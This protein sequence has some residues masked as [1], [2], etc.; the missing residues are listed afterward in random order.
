[1]SL[2]GD[3][4]YPNYQKDLTQPDQLHRDM[5]IGIAVQAD[6]SSKC[7]ADICRSQLLSFKTSPCASTGPGQAGAGCG[8][9][10]TWRGGDRQDDTDI[11]GRAVRA[12]L[13][14]IVT[15]PAGSFFFFF[16]PSE[17]AFDL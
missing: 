4:V 16:K 6:A 5:H 13:Q 8:A 17:V 11:L 1:M 7:A 15:A 2:T 14:L 9:A 12:K 10:G 3:L